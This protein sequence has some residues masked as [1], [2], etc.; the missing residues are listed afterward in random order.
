MPFNITI[1]SILLCID[2]SFSTLLNYLIPFIILMFSEMFSSQ[3]CVTSLP[4]VQAMNNHAI[5]VPG[6]VAWLDATADSA[7]MGGKT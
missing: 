1:C 5:N 6:G 7:N 2:E 4:C 3:N